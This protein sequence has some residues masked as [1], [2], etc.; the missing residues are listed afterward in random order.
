MY[1]INQT[2]LYGEENWKPYERGTGEEVKESGIGL[3]WNITPKFS[4]KKNE[5][6]LEKYCN[7]D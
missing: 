3:T 4:W 1:S 6:I 7:S 5:D 2:D